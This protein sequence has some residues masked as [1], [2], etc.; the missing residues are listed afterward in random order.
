MKKIKATTKSYNGKMRVV[1]YDLKFIDS[2]NNLF[3]FFKLYFM[4]M[5]A[6]CKNK[7]TFSQNTLFEL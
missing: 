5:L 2:G 1:S 4:L 6:D 3:L 7:Q